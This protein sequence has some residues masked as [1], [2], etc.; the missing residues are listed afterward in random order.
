MKLLIVGHGFVGKAV[1]YGF[2]HP[3]VEK[4]IIDPKYGTSVDSININDYDA[5]FVCV[6]TPM[7]EDGSIGFAILDSVMQTLNNANRARHKPIIIKST[8][9][10]A[11]IEKYSGAGIVYNPEFLRE[12]TAIEDF[13]NP[14]FHVFGGSYFDTKI[15]EQLYSDYSMCRRCESYHMG[16][17]EASLVKYAINSF[18]ATKVTFF[19][20]LYDVAVSENI[21]FNSV[22]NAVSADSRIGSSHMRV[23]G[24]DNKRGFGGSCFPKDTS[25][26]V[27][28]TNKM[29]LLERAI[30]INNH[31]RV[32]YVLD[33]REKEQNISFSKKEP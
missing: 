7:G 11:I 10:P 27:A 24:F 12:K 8:V 15:V 30:D 4:T 19:N 31:Y 20:Q 21:N 22:I 16:V 5:T 9:T 2:T 32:G 18:L 6:P 28:F 25:A 1:D 17:K 29:T 26:L 23:P 3:K 14:E 13:V 33:D